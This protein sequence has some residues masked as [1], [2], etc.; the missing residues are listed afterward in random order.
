M[1]GTPLFMDKTRKI[2][3]Q[4]IP[5]EHVV[6]SDFVLLPK[7]ETSFCRSNQKAANHFY[8]DNCTRHTA[9]E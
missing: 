6:Y 5:I 2:Q 9:H 7:N 4:N 3:R 1:K 8:R